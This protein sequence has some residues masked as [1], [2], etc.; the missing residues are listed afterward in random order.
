MHR[1]SSL[2]PPRK[3]L[4]SKT[5]AVPTRRRHLYTATTVLHRNRFGT[6]IEIIDK[7][8]T[9]RRQASFP[10]PR[11]TQQ[12]KCGPRQRTTPLHRADSPTSQ[13]IRN[14]HWNHR[15]ES[16]HAPTSLASSSANISVQPEPPGEA[17]Q[18]TAARLANEQY[19]SSP[20]SQHTRF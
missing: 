12:D 9:T 16:H 14:K 15:Q 20:D 5:S 3:A 13:Q 1:H 10:L 4:R 2:H 17:F 19:V 8:R 11:R 18:L 6:N 7:N